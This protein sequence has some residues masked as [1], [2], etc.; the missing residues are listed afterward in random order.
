[1]HMKNQPPEIVPTQ[2]RA[3][4]EKLSKAALMDLVWYLC[5]NY[6]PEHLTLTSLQM[7]E[8][9]RDQVLMIRE[10]CRLEQPK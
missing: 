8:Q 4:M 10:N 5:H 2:Y 6:Q 7:Y 1:M 9:A 3:A